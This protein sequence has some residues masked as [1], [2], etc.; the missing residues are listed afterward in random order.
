MK[1]E[2]KTCH[3]ILVAMLILPE[4]FQRAVRSYTATAPNVEHEGMLGYVE[5]V[6]TFHVND[7][8][9]FT[10]LYSKA[11]NLCTPEWYNQVKNGLLC[12]VGRTN[13]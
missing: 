3:S 2:I 9:A 4:E 5:T 13:A 8:E 6:V 12:K 1:I 11:R 10:T 7:L